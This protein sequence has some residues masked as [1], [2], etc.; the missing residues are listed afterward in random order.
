MAGIDV[1]ICG[2]CR[3]VDAAAAADMGARYA[4]V[5]LSP[6]YMRSQTVDSARAIFD[7]AGSVLRVGVFVDEAP[8]RIADAVRRLQ[9]V[10]VQ[11]HG[12]ETV[13]DIAQIN[14]L[15]SVRVW[16]ALQPAAASEL[17]CDVASFGGSVAG[18]LLD[19]KTRAAAAAPVSW[20]RYAAAHAALPAG[21]VLGVAGGLT[22][23]NVAHVIAQLAPDFVDV[24]SGVEEIPGQKSIEL[25]RAFL[26]AA[27]DVERTGGNADTRQPSPSTAV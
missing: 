25:M 23:L 2:L 14:A 7:A 10:V 12:R 21:V 27:A 16:K 13:A 20:R 17:A 4:G 24:S 15:S 19:N 9:L 8:A 11:L 18:I 3:A 5:I 1:K 26:A 22:P 6:G